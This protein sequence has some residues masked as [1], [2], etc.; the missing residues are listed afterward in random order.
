MKRRT[1]LTRTIKAIA[2]APLLPVCGA[3]LV[4]TAAN[5]N[6]VQFLR[7]IEAR[8]AHKDGVSCF[9][10]RNPHDQNEIHKVCKYFILNKNWKIDYLILR[11]QET[12]EEFRC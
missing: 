10:V 12:G 3:A 7:V 2:G 9:T 8:F 6:R 1:F 5:Q 11:D 4:T